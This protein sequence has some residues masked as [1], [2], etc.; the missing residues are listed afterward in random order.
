MR[1]KE[2]HHFGTFFPFSGH[3]APAHREKGAVK[4]AM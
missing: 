3:S 1:K 4:P 2:K